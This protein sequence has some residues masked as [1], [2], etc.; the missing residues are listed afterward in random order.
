METGKDNEFVIEK[1]KGKLDTPISFEK[2]RITCSSADALEDTKN[3]VGLVVYSIG[4]YDA[5]KETG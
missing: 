3:Y 5:K 1:T 2:T 4:T